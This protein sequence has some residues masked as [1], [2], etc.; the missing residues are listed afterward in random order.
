VSGPR[1]YHIKNV[2]EVFRSFTCPV[3]LTLFPPA[4]Y[5]RPFLS[6]GIAGVVG[7]CMAAAQ[8]EKYMVE[9][10]YTMAAGGRVDIADR[11]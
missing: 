5:C 8:L 9:A 4:I 2:I 6:T 3:D 7:H 10:A 1:S 11:R